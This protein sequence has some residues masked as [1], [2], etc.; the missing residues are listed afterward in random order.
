MV[1]LRMNSPHTCSTYVRNIGKMAK[2]TMK[3]HEALYK[4]GAPRMLNMFAMAGRHRREG[5]HTIGGGDSSSSIG[6]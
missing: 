5:I 4:E 1:F 6:V 3:S 2:M